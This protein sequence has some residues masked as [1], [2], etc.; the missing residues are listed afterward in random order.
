MAANSLKATLPSLQS[1]KV[2]R[3][4]ILIAENEGEKIF[5]APLLSPASPL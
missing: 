3:E 1:L 5:S 4:S 2:S